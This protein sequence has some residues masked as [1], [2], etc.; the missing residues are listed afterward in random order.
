MDNLLPRIVRSLM[1]DFDG[2]TSAFL[3]IS[4]FLFIYHWLYQKISNIITSSFLRRTSIALGALIIYSIYYFIYLLGRDISVRVFDL[5]TYFTRIIVSLICFNLYYLFTYRLENKNRRWVLLFKFF[6]FFIL[7]SLDSFSEIWLMNFLESSNQSLAD[8]I[9]GNNIRTPDGPLSWENRIYFF[10]L[11]AFSNL[12]FSL[13]ATIADSGC[14]YV[15]RLQVLRKK[16]KELKALELKEQLTRAQLETLHA[17]INPHFLYNSLNSIAGL[18]KTDGDKTQQMAV[19]LSKFFR[20]SINHDQDNLVP[21]QEELEMVK[22]Y[23]EIEKIRFE[24]QLNY[25]ITMEPGLEQIKIPRFILQPLVENSVK[26]GLK[27]NEHKLFVC[28]TAQKDGKKLNLSVQ[29][30]GLPFAEGFEPGYGL[31]SVYDKLDILFP[32]KYEVT[33]FNTPMKKV[34]IQIET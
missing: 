26:H 2:M 7:F 16:G 32:D 1:A 33:L 23:L 27:G 20:Y 30:D 11:V 3:L 10:K 31:K 8:I 18:A 9:I 17:K 13:F 15:I 19:S 29:D 25:E 34:S 5:H 21:L 24:E 22:T 28:I 4:A 6:I 12:L 14:R